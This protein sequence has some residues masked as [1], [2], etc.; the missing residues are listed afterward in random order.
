MGLVNCQH[1]SCS[2][3]I[4]CQ[5]LSPLVD[6]VII[7]LTREK[8]NWLTERGNRKV[9]RRVRG[10]SEFIR[11]KEVLHFVGWRRLSCD[12]RVAVCQVDVMNTISPTVLFCVRRNNE[13]KSPTGHLLIR[14]KNKV[15]VHLVD[16]EH[17]GTQ[18]TGFVINILCVIYG[19]NQHYYDVLQTWLLYE[20]QVW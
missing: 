14:L 6:K 4:A 15:P 9:T 7:K 5:I 20:H 8:P 10:K 11:Q 19:S 17:R 2:K 18:K 12:D 1:M 16:R 13:V 3:H